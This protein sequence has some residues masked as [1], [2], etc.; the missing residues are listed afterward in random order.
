MTANDIAWRFPT[1]FALALQRLAD[2]LVHRRKPR[3]GGPP[4]RP[5]PEPPPPEQPP[6]AD[7]WD[8]PAL[9]MLMIH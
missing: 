1:P 6:S 5:T 7:P 9:W 3:R 8:D 4:P 2:A